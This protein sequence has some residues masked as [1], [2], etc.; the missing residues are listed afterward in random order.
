MDSVLAGMLADG[1]IAGAY[2]IEGSQ[3]YFDSET[4][5]FIGSLFCLE[6]SRC[7][8]CQPCIQ[9]QAG[10]HP[11]ILRISPSG[12]SIKVDDIADVAGWIAQKPF[13]GGYK[14]VVIPQADC[15]VEAAQNKL[16]KAIEEPPEQTV[17]LL[18]A[19]SR[20][21]LLPTVLSRCIIIRMRREAGQGLVPDLQRMFNISTLV[22]SMLAKTAGGDVYAA[23]ALFARNYPETREVCIRAARRLLEAKNRATSVILD[24]LL[25]YTENLDDAF[26][27]MELYIRDIVVYQ[28]TGIASMLYNGDKIVEIKT[29]AQ[30]LPAYKLVR[31]LGCLQ[32]AHQKYK[33][34]AGILKKLLLESML[35]EILEVVL[36]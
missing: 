3:G 2:L 4:E 6:H 24:M 29:Y 35:F 33:N 16:L 1:R 10:F 15:M 5:E 12:Q 28:K 36:T 14:A 23:S 19:A 30:S 21:N 22:A 25:Q 17:F 27:A 8:K 7:G 31:I 11:D 34:C 9:I 13:E 18:G 32:A 26:M 20:K